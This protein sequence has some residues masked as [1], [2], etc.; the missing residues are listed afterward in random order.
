MYAKKTYIH[1]ILCICQIRTIFDFLTIK[2]IK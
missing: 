1:Y 2:Y